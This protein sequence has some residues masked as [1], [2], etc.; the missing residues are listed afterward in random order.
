MVKRE[1]NMRTGTVIEMAVHQMTCTGC[2]AEANASCNCGKPYVPKKQRAADAV[3][4]NPQKSDRAIAADIGVSPMTVNRARE[5]A[6]VTDGTPERE[7]LDGKVYRLPV[8]EVEPEGPREI[9]ESFVSLVDMALRISDIDLSAVEV[10]PRMRKAIDD[11]IEAW[12]S[13]REK[14]Q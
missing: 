6:G 11:V 12:T 13:A 8:R 10:T 5:E 14:L 3:A 1:S 7:G 4:A 2:G 9:K